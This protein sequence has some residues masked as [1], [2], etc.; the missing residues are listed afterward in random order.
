MHRVPR[1]DLR[2]HYSGSCEAILRCSPEFTAFGTVEVG[3][4]GVRSVTCT[5]FGTETINVSNINGLGA[6]EIA[7]ITPTLQTLAPGREHDSS[8]DLHTRPTVVATRTPFRS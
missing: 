8:N 6:P 3:T 7:V 1:I 4:S 2:G 5:N